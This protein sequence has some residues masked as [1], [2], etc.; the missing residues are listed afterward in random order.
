MSLL[1]SPQTTKEQHKFFSK[2]EK[3]YNKRS[4]LNCT[5][6][7]T[8]KITSRLLIHSSRQ[9]KALKELKNS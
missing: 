1:T 2:M 5:S 7:L 4:F 6:F 8:K 9:T 3:E